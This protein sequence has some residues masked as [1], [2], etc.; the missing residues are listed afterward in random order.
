MELYGIPDGLDL[1]WVRAFLRP[2][3]YRPMDEKWMAAATLER[4][5]H[6][7]GVAR[8]SWLEFLY[9]ERTLLAAAVLV[10]LC[11]YATGASPKLKATPPVDGS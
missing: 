10:G 8:A 1:D 7:P 2:L 11:I 4:L 3:S 5:N 6:L 9:Y